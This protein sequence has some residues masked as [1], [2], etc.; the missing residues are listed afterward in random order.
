MPF[1]HVISGDRTVAEGFEHFRPTY[2]HERLLAEADG[3]ASS[4]E[5]Q[6]REF[7]LLLAAM[8]DEEAERELE[9]RPE[10]AAAQTPET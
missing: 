10:D 8:T 5:Q 1:I 2:P 4:D 9:E 7:L 3:E 6:Q